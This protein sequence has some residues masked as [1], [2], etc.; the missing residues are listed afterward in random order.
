[1]MNQCVYGWGSWP[2]LAI[3]DLSF[4]KLNAVDE[5]HR[6]SRASGGELFQD[7]WRRLVIPVGPSDVAVPTTLIT[8]VLDTKVVSA[9]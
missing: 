2:P 1:M 9:D 5:D 3:G 4:P 8:I 6:L 7:N